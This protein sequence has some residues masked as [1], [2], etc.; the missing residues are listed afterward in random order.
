[1]NLQAI[2]EK[3]A[4]KIQ[5][6]RALADKAQAENRQMT[7]EEIA[8]FDTI[9]AAIQGLEQEEARAQFLTDLERRSTGA[10]VDNS[11]RSME[12]S[13]NVLDAIRCQVEQRSVTGALAE[14]QQEAKRQGVQARAGGILVPASLFEK[15]ATQTTTTAAGI[16]PEDYK[17][18]QYIGLLRNS[19]IVR[20][21]GAR[22]LTGC[23]GDQVFPKQTGTSTAYW[24]AEGESLTESG[25]TYANVKLSPKHVGALSAISRQ[26]L[27]QTNP[28]LEQLTR[29]DFTAVIG[30]AVDKALLH[31][32]AS[33]D[34]PV[35]ILNTSGIQTASLATLSWAAVVAML[36]KLGLSNV[37][38]NAFLA[39]TKA[40]TK[41]MT[42]L[43]AESAGA[44]YLMESGRMADLPAYATNQLED[45]G[46]TTK[47][48]RVIAGDFSQIVI[49]EWGA[50]EILANP[51]APGYYEKGD[52]QL[53]IMHTL[54]AAARHPQA[55]VVA[56]DIAL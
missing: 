29:D 8:A 38:P 5:E 34:Q 20:S 43:K 30:L 47:T 28:G 2:R 25:T 18:D 52:I 14:Y 23:V 35:G 44:A 21:L 9:K 54:D 6:A 53:R 15:R 45:K 13:V 26:A 55:F 32:V 19:A 46:T 40:A 10:P 22:V 56:D 48:G 49:A 50:A 17:A 1:M 16:V 31:G 24:V 3:R 41:L 4:A 51:Y 7:P 11:R 37:T 39:S 36:E 33:E 27:Q 42:T 12:Q